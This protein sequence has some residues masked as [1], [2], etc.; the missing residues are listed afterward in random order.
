[1]VLGAALTTFLIIREKQKRD[2]EELEQYLDGS[3]Q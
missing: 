2:D 1:M 3:I